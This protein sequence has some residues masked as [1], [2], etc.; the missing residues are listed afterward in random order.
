MIEFQKNTLPN[1]VRIITAPLHETKAMT[2]Q[3]LVGTGSR[4]ERPD[5]SGISHFLEH[6]LFKGTEK[7][8]SPLLL[9]ETL[10][11]IGAEFN[12]YTS[13]EYTGFYV[14]AEAKQFPLALDVLHEMLY[15][16]TFKLEDV[17]REKGVILEERNM[18]LDTPQRHVWDVLKELLYGDSP[19]GRNI[20]GSP[21]TIKAMTRETFT[22]YQRDSYTPDNLIISVAGNPND[23]DWL[24]SL[25]KTFSDKQGTKTRSFDAAPDAQSI[26][27]VR[28]DNRRTDQTHMVLAL[29]TFKQNDDRRFPLAVLSTI[30]GGTMSSRLFNEVREKRG[31]AYYVRSAPDAYHDAGMFG[32]AAGVNNSQAKEALAVIL[33]EVKRMKDEPVTEPELN[34]AKENFRG[35]MALQLEESSAMAGY[36]ADQELYFGNLTQ[37]EALLEKVNA[38]TAADVQAIANTFFVREHLNLAVVGPFKEEEF[39]TILQSAL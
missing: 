8:P 24:A 30:L 12:A 25:T 14:N 1:G 34:R 37:P 20:V 7:Y 26:P 6:I 28:V 18:Y 38:V 31:L 27:R 21:E 10:D 13:E 4:F 17:E 16:P 2:L 23:I 3:F 32:I 36:L 33:S 9:A 15:R 39:G 29:R 5:E 22:N 19:L 11:G 35:R